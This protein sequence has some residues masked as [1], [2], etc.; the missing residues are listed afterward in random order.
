MIF[1]ICLCF[2][3]CVFVTVVGET[4]REIGWGAGAL[5]LD[6]ESTIFLRYLVESRQFFPNFSYM[7]QKKV[8]EHFFLYKI[9]WM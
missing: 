7:N 1:C 9:T 8:M 6:E 2:N 3:P 4:I 5:K